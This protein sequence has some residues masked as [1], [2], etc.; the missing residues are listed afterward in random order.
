MAT[1]IDGRN[2]LQEPDL[3]GFNHTLNQKLNSILNGYQYQ[4]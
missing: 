3:Q 1:S 2:E 4:E